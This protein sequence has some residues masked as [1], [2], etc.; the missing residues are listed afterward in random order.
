M[1]E[2]A[3][4]RAVEAERQGSEDMV[5]AQPFRKRLLLSPP[6]GVENSMSWFLT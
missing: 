2:A 1:G 6:E 3:P 4:G 5:K